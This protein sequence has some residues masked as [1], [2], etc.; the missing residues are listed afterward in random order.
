MRIF[1]PDYSHA[2]GVTGMDVCACFYFSA[3]EMLIASMPM[4]QFVA[5]SDALRGRICGAWSNHTAATE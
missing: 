1:H 3:L 2:V 4:R 5:V